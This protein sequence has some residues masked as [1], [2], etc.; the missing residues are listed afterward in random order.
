MPFY[1][2]IN[3]R[4]QAQWVKQAQLPSFSGSP[5]VDYQIYKTHSGVV[6]VYAIAKDEYYARPQIYAENNQG[7]SDN[8]ARFA[9]LSCA[10]LDCAKQIDFKPDIVHCNDWHA[11]LVPLLLKNRYWNDPFFNQAKS[12]ITIHNAIFQGICPSDQVYLIPEIYTKYLVQI[13][14]TYGWINFLKAGAIFAD[15]INAVSPNYANELLT[16]EG[17]CGLDP[18]LRQRH[19]DFAGIVNGCDYSDWN[20]Q[21]DPYL[22]AHYNSNPKSFLSG[23]ALCKQVLQKQLHL[24]KKEVPLYGMVCRLTEQKGVHLLIS[25]LDRFLLNDVHLVIEG[26]GDPILAQQ[27]TTIALRHPQKMKFIDRYDNK[28]AHLIEAASDFFMMPSVFEPCGLNQLYS[29]A[30]GTLPIVRAV[31][32]L[33]DTVVD[34][35]WDKENAT[36]F[37]FSDIDAMDFLAKLQRA[38]ILY[39]QDPDEFHRIQQQAMHQKFYWSDVAEKYL[40]LYF[41]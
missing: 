30:Y 2:T 34:Y 12:I 13:E 15:M 22:P 33:Q 3:N 19:A 27:L 11:G 41:K 5:V 14:E 36:G 38:L 20:A 9:F 40:A 29:M 7:Y 35:D 24:P 18:I 17:G 37:V 31:G 6:P 16:P 8:G 26:T 1:S 28:L 25:I 4:D 23:K 32:G 39:L 21:V 10:A